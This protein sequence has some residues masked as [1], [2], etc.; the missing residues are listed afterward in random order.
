MLNF[1]FLKGFFEEA[2]NLIASFEEAEF[3]RRFR[4]LKKRCFG[5]TYLRSI[6]MIIREKPKICKFLV[7]AFQLTRKKAA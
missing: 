5:R 3:E 4:T 2:V 6:A 7:K 1:L